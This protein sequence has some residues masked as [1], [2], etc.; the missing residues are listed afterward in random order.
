MIM[1]LLNIS[2]ENKIFIIQNYLNNNE[3]KYY[4]ILSGVIEK[5]NLEHSTNINGIF[6]NLSLLDDDI[7]NDIY[8][9][10]TNSHKLVIETPQDE[11]KPTQ[12]IKKERTKI[13]IDKLN[14]D[15]LDK[16]ILQKSR[17][18]ISI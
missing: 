11:I 14:L 4:N 8:I 18:N 7:L 10:F 3:N 15:K 1:E 6:L 16:F 2:K 17:T 12:I 5:Y 13:E 9:G